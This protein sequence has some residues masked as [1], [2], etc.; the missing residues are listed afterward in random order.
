MERVKNIAKVE[1]N[2]HYSAWCWGWPK[3]NL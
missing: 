2:P 3:L 1:T